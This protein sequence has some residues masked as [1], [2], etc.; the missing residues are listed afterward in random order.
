M[1]FNSW[2]FILFFVVVFLLYFSLSYRW[3][4]A[5]LLVASYIFYMA[6][7]WEFAI[8]MLVVS[9][10]NFYA[11]KKIYKA[12]NE[13]VK[14]RWL[15]IAL[16]FSLT[17]LVYFKYSN[18][19]IGNFI[20]LLESI[21]I[22]SNFQYLNVI[23][24]VGIS[25]FTF[26]ALSYSLDVYNKKIN[27]EHNF[28]NFA[29]FVAF[30]PQLVAGPIER[31]SHLLSQFREKHSFNSERL[32]EG[33]KLFI[34]GLFKKIVIA[35]RLAPYVDRIYENPELYSGSTL[36]V[37][38]LFFT[39]QIYCD[40]SGYSDMAI[41]SGRILGFR[42]MQNFNLPYLAS[43]IGNFWKRWHISLSSWFADYLYI[44]LGGN[45]VKYSR[46]IFNIFVV[47]LVSGFWHGA[48][49]TFIFWGALHASYYLI[50]NFG[51]RLI[52][53]LHIEKIKNFKGYK[54]FKIVTV[55]LLVYYAWIFFRSTNISE[56]LFISEKI[57]TDWKSTLYRGPSTVTFVFSVL[58]IVFLMIVQLFQYFKISSLYFSK[59]RTHPALQF[60]WYVS[61]MIC[62][63]LF[64]MSSNAFIYFQF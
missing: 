7:K 47:F 41:G 24:P 11:G 37:A 40:F 50:E 55:F 5:I 13:K 17:P 62:I 60:A 22:N 54:V 59:P 29:V 58:L 63:S 4:P 26:Q 12:N 33:S 2:Q 57:I 61:L 10:L 56:A 36:A 8:L 19:F 9:A 48:N 3:R 25:F 46:W 14:N 38:T 15:A 28:I 49:L 53:V 6:W 30:F 51:E 43:S 34:W 42:L 23:L 1:L 44:P 32:L 18:F 31:S 35:D 64:G 20:S 45:R 52:K 21:G 16:I 39:I 27:I